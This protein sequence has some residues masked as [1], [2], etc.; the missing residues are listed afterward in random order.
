MP[1]ASCLGLSEKGSAC[2]ENIE[3]V[4]GNIFWLRFDVKNKGIFC[5]NSLSDV[6]GRK[7]DLTHFSKVTEK[8]LYKSLQKNSGCRPAI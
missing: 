2:S 3:T 8:H 1:I 4:N 6:F 5:R 7:D